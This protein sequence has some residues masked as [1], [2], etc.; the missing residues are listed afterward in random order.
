L[1]S[2]LHENSLE[3][4]VVVIKRVVSVAEGELVT[5]GVAVSVAI[6]VAVVVLIVS[7]VV[8]IIAVVGI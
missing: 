8:L 5:I 1:E 3:L 6:E 7:V 4:A 2:K